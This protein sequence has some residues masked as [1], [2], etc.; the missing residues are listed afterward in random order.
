MTAKDCVNKTIRIKRQRP[1]EL[2]G[3]KA[4]MTK[5]DHG[6]S[7]SN[8]QLFTT[9]GNLYIC[10]TGY[11]A[12]ALWGVVEKYKRYSALEIINTVNWGRHFEDA[13]MKLWSKE[14]LDL[15]YKYGKLSR[16]S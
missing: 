15:G 11:R 5:K 2:R 16:L 3:L 12:K 14:G 13:V 7:W 9:G 6:Y 10:L 1:K 4:I 8:V